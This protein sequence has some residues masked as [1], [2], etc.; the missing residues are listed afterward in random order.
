MLRDR[1][2]GFATTFPAVARL[3]LGLRLVSRE[4]LL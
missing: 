2:Y 4:E 3:G 1:P